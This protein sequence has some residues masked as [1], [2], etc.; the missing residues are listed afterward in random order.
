MNIDEGP[1]RIDR[2]P[3]HCKVADFQLNDAHSALLIASA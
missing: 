1:C 3:T 2:L